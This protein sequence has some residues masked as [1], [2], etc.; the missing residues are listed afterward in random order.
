MSYPFITD[1]DG[2][3]SENKKHSLNDSIEQYSATDFW[4]INL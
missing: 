1:K 4:V 2:F 3:D